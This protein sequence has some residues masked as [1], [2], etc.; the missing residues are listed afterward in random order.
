MSENFNDDTFMKCFD[1]NTALMQSGS[2]CKSLYFETHN[3]RKNKECIGLHFVGDAFHLT[4]LQLICRYHRIEHTCLMK[5]SGKIKQ[6]R[7]T[8]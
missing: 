5:R 4:A 8:M 3:F 1:K 2:N 6:L 7:T